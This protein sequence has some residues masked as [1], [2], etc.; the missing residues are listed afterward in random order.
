[1]G[2]P[3]PQF[4]GSWLSSKAGNDM[5][6]QKVGFVALNDQRFFSLLANLPKLLCEAE[7]CLCLSRHRGQRDHQIAGT[8]GWMGGFAAVRLFV[9]TWIRVEI[10]PRFFHVFIETDNKFKDKKRGGAQGLGTLGCFGL[11]NK[12]CPLHWKAISL[13]PASPPPNNNVLW[14][15]IFG[16]FNHKHTETRK[17][18]PKILA[19]H[20]CIFFHNRRSQLS[21]HNPKLS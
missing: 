16:Q 5:D 21:F 13:P 12:K 11:F 10:F 9:K 4:P 18:H 19:N 2:L 14:C 15:R 8:G 7:D 6:H 17:S 3:P 20:S 1:M